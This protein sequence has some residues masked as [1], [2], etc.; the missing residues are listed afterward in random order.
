MA[1]RLQLKVGVLAESDRFEDSADSILVVEPTIGSVARTKGSFHLLVSAAPGAASTIARA[2]EAAAAVVEVVR[3][4]YFYDE[5]A[6][7]VVCLQK[8]IRAA[9]KRLQLQHKKLGLGGTD[10]DGPIGV[11]VAVVR[12]GEV[13]LATTGPAEAYI[14]RQARILAL[15]D[16]EPRPGLPNPAPDPFIWRGETAPGD[17]IVLLSSGIT[18]AIP[19]DELKD[20]IVTLHPQS[21]IDRIHERLAGERSAAGPPIGDGMIV[22]EVTE[23]PSTTKAHRLVPAQPPEPRAGQPDRSPIPLADTLT[24]GVAAAQASAKGVGD[25]AK[26]AAAGI[27]GRA[28]DHLPE[29]Q[30]H[31]RRVVPAAAKVENRR[32]LALAVLAVVALVA[33]L[34]IGGY[35]VTSPAIPLDNVAAGE[36][37]LKLVRSDIDQVFGQGRDLVTT[38]ASTAQKLLTDAYRQLQAATTAKVP[39]S[40]L[41]PL[42]TQVNTGLDRLFHVTTVPSTL[43]Y[44]F[45][46][47]A[48]ATGASPAASTVPGADISALVYGPDGAAY[49]L[50]RASKSVYRIDLN[51]KTAAP[52]YKAGTILGGSTMGEPRI[53]TTGGPDVLILDNANQLWRWRPADTTGRGTPAKIKIKEATTWG[54]DIRAIGTFIQNADAGLYRLYVVDPAAK[55]ILRYSPAADG[56]GYPAAATAYLSTARELGTVSSI[57]VDGDIYLIQDAKVTR[58][59]SGRPGEWQPANPDDSAMR[60]NPSYTLVTSPTSRGAGS[61]YEYDHA[62]GRLL[63]IEKGSGDVLQQFVPLQSVP[64]AVSWSDLRGIWV[65]NRSD[66]ASPLL[67]WADATSIHTSV[68]AKVSTASPSPGASGATSSATTSQS[69][70]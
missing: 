53:L 10:L 69:A 64:D 18:K 40:T 31:Y 66:G 28:L 58:Y 35:F 36:K 37:A 51:A 27:F 39:D 11:A 33:V 3:T 54:T 13:Y 2:R 17:S 57:F 15:P 12:E 20:D 52:V 43:I 8:A 19:L 49:V 5:S 38:D 67:I 59:A 56:S 24:D 45:P 6:G 22:L 30:T 26:G 21:A 48:S 61:L 42:R 34:G 41:A 62:N 9:N 4:E 68:L 60:P 16:P 65:A 55:Q 23:V 63:V 14:V 1:V 47:A 44:D 25:A 7:I 46:P 70:P 32:R 29:R 50:D